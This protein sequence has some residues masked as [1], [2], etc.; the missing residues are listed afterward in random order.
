MLKFSPLQFSYRVSHKKV[1]HFSEL[2]Q[3]NS[4]HFFYQ[5]ARYSL[6][7]AKLFFGTP[8]KIKKVYNPKFYH[9]LMFN[10]LTI[11]PIPR[12][13]MAGSSCPPQSEGQYKT[14]SHNF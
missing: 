7:G 2:F 13:I 10:L 9:F 14:C 6:T 11:F 12:Q 3:E 5:T 4:C 1:Y 8:G